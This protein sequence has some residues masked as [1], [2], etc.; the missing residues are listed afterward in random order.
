MAPAAGAVHITSGV[1][2]LETWLGTTYGGEGVIHA[3]LGTAALMTRFSVT[4]IPREDECIRTLAGD[5][6]VLGAGYS[7]NQGPVADV[8]DPEPAPEGEAWLYIT[9]P[10]RIRR[11]DRVIVQARQVQAVDTAVNDI[12]VLAETVTP[13]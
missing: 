7:A 12:R 2:L 5:S 8:N 13:P 4:R 1:G 6:V 3:P 11:D 10:M 9:P